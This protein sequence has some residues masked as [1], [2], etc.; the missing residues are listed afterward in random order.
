MGLLKNTL[1]E[2]GNLAGGDKPNVSNHLLE[3]AG[4]ESNAVLKELESQSNGLSM[5]EAEAH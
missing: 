1:K 3:M 2:R 5:A 4:K